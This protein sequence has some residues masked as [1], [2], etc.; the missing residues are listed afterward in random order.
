MEGFPAVG[1]PRKAPVRS[2]EKKWGEGQTER[3]KAPEPRRALVRD[4][5]AIPI[6]VVRKTMGTPR[7]QV[8]SRAFYAPGAPSVISM[9]WLEGLDPSDRFGGIKHPSWEAFW[10]A[11]FFASLSGSQRGLES[12]LACRA[13]GATQRA[14]ARRLPTS[15]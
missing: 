13:P 9:Y 14:D 11:G 12:S 6:G 1:E 8:E 2:A 4:P 3:G 5:G 15:G 10:A 7:E